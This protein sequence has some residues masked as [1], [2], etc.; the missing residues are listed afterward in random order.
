[1]RIGGS[2]GAVGEICGRRDG[3]PLAI[4]LAAARVR[5]LPPQALASRLSQRFSLLTGGARDL[6]P[7]QQT[8]RNTLD[9]SF[10][11]LPTGEQAL[12]A[13]LGVVAGSFS[14]PAAPAIGGGGPRQGQA[15]A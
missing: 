1:E 13:P 12:L 3:L 6:P 10:E 7:R 15:G 8:L 4:E 2:G 5:L 11:L 14:L 9:W